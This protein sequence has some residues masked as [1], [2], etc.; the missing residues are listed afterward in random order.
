MK[1]KNSKALKTKGIKM[2]ISL[3]FLC[4]LLLQT[5]NAQKAITTAGSDASGTAGS[6]S[7]TVGQV[8][9]STSSGSNGSVTQ[10]VQQPYEIS[11]STALKDTEDITLGFSA[12]PNPTSDILKL[13]T[14]E[15]DFNDISYK[16][17]DVNGKL[18]K[19]DKITG[20][21]TSV[22]MQ[23][24]LP[25][26]YFIKMIENGKEIKIFKIIKK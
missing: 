13:K 26:V 22:N 4:F 19:A 12:Y 25:S 3:L 11:V 15:R 7:Y 2:Y 8:T 5:T 17:F 14:G 24:L 18:I 9:Y 21:E 1:N 16:L 10:G 20:S 23:N 6:I